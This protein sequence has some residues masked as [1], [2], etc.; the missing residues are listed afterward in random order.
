MYVKGKKAET[1]KKKKKKED[2]Q[3]G[4]FWIYNLRNIIKSKRLDI[5][6]FFKE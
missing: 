5:E 3:K 2:W 6:G 1:K 4:N